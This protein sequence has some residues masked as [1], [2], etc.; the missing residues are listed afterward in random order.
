MAECVG[1]EFS[2]YHVAQMST[3]SGL[4]GLTTTLLL[5]AELKQML[6]LSQPIKR[7]GVSPSEPPQGAF[8]ETR[9]DVA[10]VEEDGD[11]VREDVVAEEKQE[12]MERN[13]NRK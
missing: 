5:M 1:L 8:W 11:E 3:S 10:A 6:V 9:G 13:T 7:P 12:K 4:G 2:S